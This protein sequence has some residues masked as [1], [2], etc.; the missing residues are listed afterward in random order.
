MTTADEAWI[1][2]IDSLRVK[3]GTNNSF[4]SNIYV[5]GVLSAFASVLVRCDK[6]ERLFK[7]YSDEMMA[8]VLDEGD[9]D[10]WHER[11]EEARSEAPSSA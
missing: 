1:E 6:Y 4:D 2:A 7:M 10:I 3:Y 8:E 5:S 11:K 9:M